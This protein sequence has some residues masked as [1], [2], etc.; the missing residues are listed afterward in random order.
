[1]EIKRILRTKVTLAF[2]SKLVL[3]PGDYE[4]DRIPPELEEE[5]KLGSAHVEEVTTKVLEGKGKTPAQRA[6]D[7]KAARKAEA[8]AKAEAEEQDRAAQD[9]ARLG[10]AQRHADEEAAAK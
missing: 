9:E 7:A 8:K 4:G 6:S 3:P 10:E 2:G 1:M 5:F